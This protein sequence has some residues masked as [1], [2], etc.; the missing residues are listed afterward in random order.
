MLSSRTIGLEY[1]GLADY[2]AVYTSLFDVLNVDIGDVYGVQQ[3]KKRWAVDKLGTEKAYR[4]VLHW[5]DGRSF[6]LLGVAG[7][8]V[9][10]DCSGSATYGSVHGATLEFPE[11]LLR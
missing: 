5:F 10:S 1:S 4:D 6:W 11:V 7:T 8:V 2:P 3:I 9:L